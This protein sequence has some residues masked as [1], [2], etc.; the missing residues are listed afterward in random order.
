MDKTERMPLPPGAPESGML[1]GRIRL[2]EEKTSNL[3]RKI[4]LLESNVVKGNKTKNDTLRSFDND[5]LELKRDLA[6][7]KQKVD[8]II[9]ELKMTAGKDE[10]NT[11]KRYLDLWNLTRFITR[12][13]VE[14]MMEENYKVKKAEIGE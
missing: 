12:E 8:L 10:L 9:R 4:E 3:N 13:E 5:L 1:N 2:L 7:V 11:I 14:R 6:A